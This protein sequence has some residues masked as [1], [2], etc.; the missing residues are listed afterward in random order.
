MEISEAEDT[1]ICPV[2]AL[3][4]Y[5]KCCDNT[6]SGA[7]FIHEDMSLLTNFQFNYV[8]KRTTAYAGIPLDGISCHSLRIAA[9]SMAHLAGFPENRLMQFSRLRSQA[10]KN[11]ICTASDAISGHSGDCHSILEQGTRF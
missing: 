4:E 10:Y 8:L 7:L 3:F 5:L 9:C 2:R 11:Y 1:S 6:R